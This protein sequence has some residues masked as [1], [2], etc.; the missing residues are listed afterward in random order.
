MKV[1]REGNEGFSQ[2]RR[3]EKNEKYKVLL[4]LI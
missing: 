1:K 3:K 4:V 2:R